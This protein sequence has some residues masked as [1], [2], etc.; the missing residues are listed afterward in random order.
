M[1]TSICFVLVIVG[2]MMYTTSC[3]KESATDPKLN[4]LGLTDSLPTDSLPHDSTHFPHDS[5]HFPHDTVPHHPHDSTHF[6]HDTV[7]QYPH[8]TFPPYYPPHDSVP[9]DSVW[10]M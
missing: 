9:G 10:I 6:P 2:G 1:K 3:K 5:T 8:D 4:L 7:P